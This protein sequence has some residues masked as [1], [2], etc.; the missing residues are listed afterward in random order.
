MDLGGGAVS[1]EEGGWG[2]GGGGG[3]EAYDLCCSS[4]TCVVA[5]DVVGGGRE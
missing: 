1:L 4:W 2:V 5:L 3:V